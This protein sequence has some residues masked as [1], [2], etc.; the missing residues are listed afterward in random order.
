[1]T[2]HDTNWDSTVIIDGIDAAT[3]PSGKETGSAVRE[4]YYSTICPP[5]WWIRLHETRSIDCLLLGIAIAGRWSFEKPN[6]RFKLGDLSS[7]VIAPLC[8]RLDGRPHRGRL[9]R[10]AKKLEKASLI[11]IHRPGP[12]KKIEIEIVEGERWVR[13]L[14]QPKY[15]QKRRQ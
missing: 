9:N 15:R 4:E 1:M 6:F 2:T 12:G 10:A 3:S 7:P 11:R 8:H 5:D 14:K 13:L